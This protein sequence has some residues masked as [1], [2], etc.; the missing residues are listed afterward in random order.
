MLGADYQDLP[1][2]FAKI[3]LPVTEEPGSAG[4]AKSRGFTPFMPFG[5]NELLGQSLAVTPFQW[6]TPDINSPVARRY[7]D[8]SLRLRTYY[9]SSIGAAALAG[10]A[11]IGNVAVTSN[12]SLVHVDATIRAA[13]VADISDVLLTYTAVVVVFVAIIMT[14]VASL[15]GLAACSAF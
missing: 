1:G 3:N 7:L 2:Y 11:T 6:S 13:T 5:L 8:S 15:D 14:I 4:A 9:S 12:G 10:P